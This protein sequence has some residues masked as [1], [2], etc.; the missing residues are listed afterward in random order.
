[1]LLPEQPS[2]EAALASYRNLQGRFPTLLDRRDP[3]IRSA[4]GALGEHAYV[5]GVGPFAKPDEAKNLCV[6]LKRAGAA[7][8]VGEAG[9]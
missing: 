5:A 2:L 1:V 3:I 4:V 7:C 6:E 8:D 9:R